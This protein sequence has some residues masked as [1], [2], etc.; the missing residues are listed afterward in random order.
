MAA[1]F[2]LLF[3][4]LL[5]GLFITG[6]FYFVGNA[7]GGIAFNPESKAWKALL[8]KLRDRI[9]LRSTNPLMPCDT[10]MLTHLSLKP[11]ILKKAG[12]RDNTIE[13]VFSTIYQE[14]V[15]LFAGQK[16]GNNFIFLA[17][18][19]DKEFIFRQKGKEVEI[20]QDGKP[21]AVFINGT[22]LSSGK[23]SQMLAK[24]EFD[25]EL[26]QWPVLL[27]HGEAATITN[28]ERA[29]SPIP[30]AVMLLRNLTTEEEQVLLLL[31][32]VQGLPR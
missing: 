5:G 26:R 17:K 20:W 11:K 6:L 2:R 12:W 18:T 14:P 19:I 22:L 7:L 9:R 21:Y 3:A 23:Q 4:T 25:P 29:V 32:V 8:T 31:T 30:R 27:D 15:L 28:A 13:G 1:L 24:L 10:E 16:N